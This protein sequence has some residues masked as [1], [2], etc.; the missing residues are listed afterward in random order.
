MSLTLP[1]KYNTI[2]FKLS[3][4]VCV[5]TVFYSIILFSYFNYKYKKTLVDSAV[6][7]AEIWAKKYAVEIK[8]NIEPA[9]DISRTIAQIF[10]AQKN[11]DSRLKLSRE[12]GNMIIKNLLIRNKYLLGIYTAWE[13]NQFDGEDSLYAGKEGNH[14]QGHYVPYWYRDSKDNIA[15][16]ASTVS[17]APSATVSSGSWKLQ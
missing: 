16:A 8:S 6:K 2:R 7:N 12:D 11:M 13:P 9:L 4:I 1:P 15:Y 10:S 5:S 3:L 17:L 14:P